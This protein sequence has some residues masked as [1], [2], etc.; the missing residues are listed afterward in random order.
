MPGS[1]AS[2]EKRA[3]QIVVGIASMVP[4]AAGA[5]GALFGPLLVGNRAVDAPDLDSHFRYLSGCYW[6]SASP[7]RARC[8]GSSDGESDF[9]C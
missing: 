3:L 5:A 6:E 9:F 7:M 1:S 8:P 2:K 4:I